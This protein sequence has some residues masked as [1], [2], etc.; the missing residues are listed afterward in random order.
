MICWENPS[1][2]RKTEKDRLSE[3]QDI[4]NIHDKGLDVTGSE[5]SS[6]LFSLPVVIKCGTPRKSNFA[7][8]M[9][10]QK[11]RIKKN[12]KSRSFVIVLQ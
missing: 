10:P 5:R 12:R 4:I 8:L 7:N 9:I 11:E 1:R 6:Y 3:D 2:G